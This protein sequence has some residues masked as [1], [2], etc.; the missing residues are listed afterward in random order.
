MTE[1]RIYG[2]SDDLIELEGAI[3]EELNVYDEH[4]FT[5]TAPDGQQITIIGLYLPNGTWAFAPAIT[6]DDDDGSLPDWNITI[7]QGNPDFG[8]PAY[9]TVLV[10]DVPDGTVLD[11]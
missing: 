5:L 1:L 10:L 6:G 8:E 7:R 4:H 3:E 11:A 9:T 2:A